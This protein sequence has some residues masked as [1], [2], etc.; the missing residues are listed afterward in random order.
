MRSSGCSDPGAEGAGS[1]HVV[2]ERTDAD[3]SHPAAGP[4]P[5]AQGSV[6]HPQAQ[7]RWVHLI[8]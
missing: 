1:V 8:G 4:D 2:S 6:Q 7:I 3:Y 5:A